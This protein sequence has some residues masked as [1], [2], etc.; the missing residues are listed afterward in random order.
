MFRF[1]LIT[2]IIIKAI[3]QNYVTDSFIRGSVPWAISANSCKFLDVSPK[4]LHI[5]E[6]EEKTERRFRVINL[7]QNLTW[8]GVQKRLEAIYSADKDLEK[9]LKLL[10][11]QQIQS[12]F[13][14]KNV[15]DYITNV[16]PVYDSKITERFI[17]QYNPS[18]RH[19][20]IP[21]CPN[22][23]PVHLIPYNDGI[24]CFCCLENIKIQWPDERGFQLKI[25]EKDLIFLVNNAPLFPMHFT[26]SSVEHKPM[27]MDVATISNICNQLPGCWVIQNGKGAGA[28]NPWHYHLQSFKGSLPL[29]NASAVSSIEK[30]F[31]NTFYSIEKLDYPMTIYRFILPDPSPY[32]VHHL[33]LKLAEYLNL[34]K[35][36]TFNILGIKPYPGSPLNLLF[37]P[38]TTENIAWLYPSGQLGYAEIGGVFCTFDQKTR[39]HW[40]KEGVSLFNEALKAISIGKDLEQEL[41]KILLK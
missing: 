1:Y 16:T 33:G 13:L 11:D 14:K 18:R 20:G 24:P 9:V 41:D 37:A 12:G 23:N 22:P 35:K 3:A 8:N 15:L 40:I 6:E 34:S 29:S 27:F 5:E 2:M 7:G 26:I 39:D 38:R 4:L 21:P 10:Y 25:L 31:N 36:N 28:S 30:T 17:I 19:R 32:L